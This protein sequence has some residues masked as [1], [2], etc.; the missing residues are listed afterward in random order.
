[1][2]VLIN[3]PTTI[4]PTSSHHFPTQIR[5]L[6]LTSLHPKLYPPRPT[7]IIPR[8]GGRRHQNC[9][10]DIL[11]NQVAPKWFPRESL[12]WKLFTNSP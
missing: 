2:Y 10:R 3:T 6:F 4:H 8:L 1:M 5:R 9:E 11:W 12:V 7:T